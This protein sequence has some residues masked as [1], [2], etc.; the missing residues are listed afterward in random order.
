MIE[1]VSGN[2]LKADADALVNTVNTVGVMGKGIALQ[3]KQAFPEVFKTYNAA[4][5]AGEIEI[6][7]VQVVPTGR[8]VG[9]K[10]VINFPTK[11]HWRSR[12]RL[13]EIRIGLDDLV[14]VIERLG[15]TSIAV[16][17][18]G[19]G[20]G[21]LEWSDVKR[22]IIKALSNLADV[23][24]LVYEPRGEPPVEQMPVGTEP[25]KWTRARALIVQLMNLYQIPDYSLTQLEV[26]KLAYF[27]QVAG[28]PLKLRFKA[29]HYGPYADN[30]F[31]LLRVLEGH[32]VR[33]AVDRSPERE[34]TLDEKAAA[35]ASEFIAD[36]Q[37]ALQHLDQVA[38]LIEGWETPYG[39]ELLATVHWIAG[40]NLDARTSVDAVTE[41]VKNWSSEK[42]RRFQSSHIATAF[43]WLK[44][45][46][47]L[48]L[49]LDEAAVEVS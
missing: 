31:H 22:A 39:M 12:S 8:L 36:D 13:D 17:P 4:C 28:E 46:G 3:F 47:W 35:G 45:N 10:F 33:G 27:L 23:R 40:R 15:I 25:P 32:M 49:S 6:G 30:L 21:G 44:Q 26:Q 29:H 7:R 18:L 41:G 5:K 34:I 1:F 38:R 2:L 42:Q 37:E 11:H 43:D 48:D 14:S 16:P 20:N 19:C 9:P 24:V